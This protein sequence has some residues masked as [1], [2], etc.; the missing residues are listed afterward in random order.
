MAELAVHD[1]RY[2]DVRVTLNAWPVLGVVLQ[3]ASNRIIE[4]R[5]LPRADQTQT[6]M[7][8]SDSCFASVFGNRHILLNHAG[9]RM[10]R[11]MPKAAVT[12]SVT[13]APMVSAMAPVARSPNGRP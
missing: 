5:V 6:L 12:A 3:Y 11:M 13:G 4:E 7:D 2:R 10:E 9:N 8:S 1:G